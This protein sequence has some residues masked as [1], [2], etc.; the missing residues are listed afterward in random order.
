MAQV[1]GGLKQPPSVVPHS[2]PAT[3][4]QGSK[5]PAVCCC[6][7]DF[8]PGR[9]WTRKYGATAR[10]KGACMSRDT[11]SCSCQ[12]PPKAFNP[13]PFRGGMQM[14]YMKILIFFL[15][16]QATLKVFREEAGFY[17]KSKLRNVISNTT[18]FCEVMLYI[19]QCIFLH[20]FSSELQ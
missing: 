8:L 7:F 13:S 9:C 20:I 4:L 16:T 17:I 18:C 10:E 3:V 6:Q 14:A 2:K 5:H 12:D 11:K 19:K 15:Q 1:S